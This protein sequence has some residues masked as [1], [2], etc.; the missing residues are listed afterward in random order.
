MVV[1]GWAGEE[2][3]L[4]SEIELLGLL[5]V[6]GIVYANAGRISAQ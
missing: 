1:P 6:F 3:P 2:L 5:E 4:L